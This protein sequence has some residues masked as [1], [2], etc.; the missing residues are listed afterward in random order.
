MNN[1]ED[2]G[3]V[4]ERLDRAFATVDWVNSYPHYS[5]HNLPIVDSDHGPILLNFEQLLPF[6]YRPFRFELMWI[7]HPNYKDMILQAWGIQTK[8]LEVLLNREETM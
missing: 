6:R 8:G 4:M 2:E 5:L 1:R 7:N 3:F